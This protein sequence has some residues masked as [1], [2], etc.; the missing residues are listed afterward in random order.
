M[1]K[2]EKNEMAKYEKI[3]YRKMKL[4]CVLLVST[5]KPV[6]TSPINAST[7]YWNLP[8]NWIVGPYLLVGMCDKI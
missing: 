2:Y 7:G 3:K 8:Q 4:I 5:I 1:A 6:V